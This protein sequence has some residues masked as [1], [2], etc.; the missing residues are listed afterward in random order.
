[1]LTLFKIFLSISAFA[2]E[3]IPLDYRAKLIPTESPLVLEYRFGP[4]T[5]NRATLNVINYPNKSSDLFFF[6]M[7]INETTSKEATQE[8]VRKNGGTF[9]YLHHFSNNRRMS[10]QINGTTYNFDPNRIFTEEGFKAD[11]SPKAN[12]ADFAELQK[13]VAWLKQN[14]MLARAGRTRP[15]VTA[16][17]NNSDDDVHGPLLSIETE[18]KIIG[19]DN[20]DV[21]INPNWDIDN[22][23]IATLRSTYDWLVAQINP[24]VSL[25]M[26]NPRN[27]G[28]LSNWMIEEGI[29]YQRG[30]SDRRYAEQL[31][32]GGSSTETIPMMALT[33]TND[34]M[35]SKLAN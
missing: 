17:H 15:M 30:N 22:F 11:V 8:L 33:A 20:L 12:A 31:D 19:K 13:F 26:P 5:N 29:E 1:M 35:F 3:D 34:N 4:G 9:I 10:I 27:I 7:H 2:T 23:Y 32:D 6:H 24:N 18:L 21:H 25:R 16:V 14:I 28:Y